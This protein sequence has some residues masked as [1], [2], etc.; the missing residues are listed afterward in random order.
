MCKLLAVDPQFR[1]LHLMEML[2]LS[3]SNGFPLLTLKGWLIRGPKI[4]TLHDLTPHRP[5]EDFLLL[6]STFRSLHNGT[7]FCDSNTFDEWLLED[8]NM[9][10][11]YEFHAK[12]L[13]MKEAENNSNKRWLLK[14]PYHTLCLPEVLSQ[15]P[16][17]SFI[18]IHRSPLKVL[19]SI[20][21]LTDTLK[22]MWGEGWETKQ[23]KKDGVLNYSLPLYMEMINR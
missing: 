3:P 1:T 22:G 13:A 16:K 23:D 20:C 9:A 5:E 14:C 7:M 11:A 6:G 10:P 2:N 19:S 21:D 4:L 15:Y 17:A 18:W 8:G 12:A